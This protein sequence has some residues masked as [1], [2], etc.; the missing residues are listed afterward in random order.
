[1][2]SHCWA[3]WANEVFL[4][5]YSKLYPDTYFYFTWE[6]RAKY[7]HYPYDINRI[8]QNEK[9]VYFY[10]ANYTPELFDKSLEI[11]IPDYPLDSIK[12]ELLL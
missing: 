3:G 4:P 5:V 12:S 9:P 6:G 8:V 7:W 10:I 2:I 11:M 1:M